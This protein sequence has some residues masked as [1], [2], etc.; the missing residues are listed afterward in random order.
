MCFLET[1]G[2]AD[3]IPLLV[4][5]GGLSSDQRARALRTP[6]NSAGLDD[7]GALHPSRIGPEDLPRQTSMHA[8]PLERASTAGLKPRGRN[9]RGLPKTTW[10]VRV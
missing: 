8:L 7:F 1:I 2:G 9:T 5:V 10:S 3:L 6:A 4:H